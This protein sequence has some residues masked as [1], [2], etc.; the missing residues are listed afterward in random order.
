[1]DILLDPLI[2]ISFS[3]KHVFVF[4]SSHLVTFC[5]RSAHVSPLP[6]DSLNLE[7]KM[8]LPSKRNEII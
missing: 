4:P 6:G 3:R 5:V 8:E 1:V 7:D 2:H